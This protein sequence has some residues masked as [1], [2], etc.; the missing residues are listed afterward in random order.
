M[1]KLYIY[2]NKNRLTLVRLLNYCGE[3][4]KEE[5]EMLQELK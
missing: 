1:L 4:K 2:R 5:E 3:D